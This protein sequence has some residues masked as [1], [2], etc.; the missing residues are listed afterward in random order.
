MR[1]FLQKSYLSKLSIPLF[2]FWLIF[3]NDALAKPVSV[4]M[5]DNHLGHWVSRHMLKK[6]YKH[7]GLEVEFVH[8]P[9][10]RSLETANRGGCDAEAN[11]SLK[12]IKRFTNL[13][14]VP[15]PMFVTKSYAFV[16]TGSKI[17]VESWDD[18]NEFTI[19]IMNGEIYAMQATEG[20]HRDIANNYNN[21]FKLLTRRS[22]DVVIGMEVPSIRELSKKEF[23][24]K[25]EKLPTPLFSATVHHFVHK[26]K[27]ELAKQID[28]AIIDLRKQGLMDQYLAEALADLAT[29][30][31]L[32]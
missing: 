7:A 9:N 5:A 2:L 1:L 32:E 21:L 11:R 4:C 23:A 17:S 24:N 22:I 14:A 13:R 8:Y 30:E 27:P 19:A 20:M 18:L 25:V 29:T 6:I 15:S 16:K 31:T 12:V 10:M 28:A 3:S 26:D